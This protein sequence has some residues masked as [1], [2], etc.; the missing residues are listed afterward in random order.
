MLA[1]LT[2]HNATFT[3]RDVDRYLVKHLTDE[4]ERASVKAKVFGCQDVI[5]LHERDTGVSIGF[6]N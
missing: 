5:A 2:R 6:E 4:A 3:E 1:A